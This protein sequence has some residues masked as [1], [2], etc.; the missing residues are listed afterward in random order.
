MA[1][2]TA[3]APAAAAT[4][5]APAAA[6]TAPAAPAPAE[7]TAAV[8]LEARGTATASAHIRSTGVAGGR[9]DA[10]L[11]R[12]KPRPAVGRGWQSWPYSVQRGSSVRLRRKIAQIRTTHTA[13][14]HWRAGAK[15][16]ETG[17]CQAVTPMTPMTMRPA[18]CM[19]ICAEISNLV[20]H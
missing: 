14:G 12:P 10:G 4:A 9:T 6:A 13:R 18:G 17:D 16:A 11:R 8:P 3:A 1:R 5:A 2:P 19:I 7:P 20:D 15:T